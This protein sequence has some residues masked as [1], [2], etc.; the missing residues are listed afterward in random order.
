MYPG[1]RPCSDNPMDALKKF[2]FPGYLLTMLKTLQAA[3][4]EAYIV[5]GSVRDVLLGI[6]PAEWDVTTNAIPEEVSK[7]FPKVVPTGLKFGTV[8]LLFG[9][10][11]KIEVTTYRDDEHYTDGRHPDNFRITNK[12]EYDLFRSE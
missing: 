7:L 8:T 2:E 6:N 1:R 10:E 12:I 11:E 5:G 4:H 9:E 3:G